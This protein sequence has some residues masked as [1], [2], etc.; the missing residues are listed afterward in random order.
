MTW[1]A[2]YIGSNFALITVVVLVV[3][4]LA[5]IAWFARNWKVAVAAVIVIAVALAYQ[6]IDK[7]A[8]ERALHE[9]KARE[10]AVL[11]KQITELAKINQADTERAL[12]DAAEIARLEALAGATPPN[13]RACL[14][15]DAARRVRAIQ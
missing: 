2:S 15:T 11:R 7:N 3:V 1:A 10:L 6:Q 5:T 13:D 8:F 12:A 9:Q 4:A 14:D